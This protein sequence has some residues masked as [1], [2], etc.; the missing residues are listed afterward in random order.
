M[1][2][3]R[4]VRFTRLLALG[5]LLGLAACQDNTTTD[6]SRE[7]DQP[8]VETAQAA[9]STPAARAARL[10]ER[11]NTRLAARGSKF[12]LVGATFFTV[13]R[14][15]PAFR[16]LRTGAR[17]PDATGLTYLIDASDLTHD[18]PQ[19]PVV[20][21]LVDAFETWDAVPRVNVGLTRV[22]DSHANPDLLDAIIRNSAGDCVDITDA[23]WQ[24]PFADIVVGGWLNEDYFA[25]C[26]G[27]ASIIAVTW[28]FSGG[29][30]NHDN[31]ADLVYAEQYF[32]DAW[33]FVTS[34]SQ[35][36]D[37]DG[38]FDIQSIEVHELGHALGLGH[39]GGPNPNQ[40][41]TLKP[42]GR[43]FSPEAVMNPF[44]LG[45]EKRDLLPT[46][47]AALRSLYARSH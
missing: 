36:L 14:G 27:S 22:A 31:F 5:T 39:F 30:V 4:T 41:F 29:D 44:S 19:G 8:A 20:N 23:S 47:L 25:D 42:N 46:D 2:N 43:V 40:P 17:W 45:G 15:V 21:A 10:A 13:G 9:A 37:F 35:Y 1:T 18:A 33:G 6:P 11:V 34:G 24:G 3:H 32:N 38:P 7:T 26:L 16:Q 28:Y 12:R